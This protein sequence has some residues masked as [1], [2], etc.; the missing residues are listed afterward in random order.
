MGRYY[1]YYS[2]VK[3]GRR[4]NKNQDE[5]MPWILETNESSKEY[6]KDWARLIQK[7]YKVDSLTCP[8]CSGKN[9]SNQRHRGRGYYK[10]DPQ[11]LWVAG[12]KSK[13]ASKNQRQ[14]PIRR[15]CKIREGNL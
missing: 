12:S 8:K 7:I 4:K 15:L 13:A 5:W 2:N 9:E 10:N 11:A 3:R 1:G 14:Y 6:R